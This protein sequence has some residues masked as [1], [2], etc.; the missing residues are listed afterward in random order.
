[1][2]RI[3]NSLLDA[4]DRINSNLNIGNNR[5]NIKFYYSIYFNDHSKQGLMSFYKNIYIDYYLNII[6]LQ[7]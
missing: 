3:N 4:C 7:N 1:M 6:M 5:D 2:M